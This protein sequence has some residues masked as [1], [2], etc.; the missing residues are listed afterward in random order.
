[1]IRRLLCFVAVLIVVSSQL[2]EVAKAEQFDRNFYST[3][4][5]LFYDPRCDDGTATA[6]KIS[7]NGKDNIEKILKFLMAP[8]QG[9]TLAQ[10]SG[11]I[12]NLMAESGQNIDAS[13]IQGGGHADKNYVPVNGTGF[14]IAQWTF[15]ARQVPLQNYMRPYNDIT[16]LDGQIGFMWSELTGTHG[17]ALRQ[18]KQTS[19]PLDAAIAFH[20]YYEGS[21]D[22]AAQVAAN[23]GGNAEKVY[24]TYV[25]EPALAGSTGTPAT[26]NVADP[27]ST[28]PNAGDITGDES[29]LPGVGGGDLIKTVKAYAWPTYKGLTTSPT[30][31]YDSAVQKA[32]GQGRYVG[33]I[34]YPGIDCGGFVTTLVIDSGFDKDYNYSGLKSKGAGYTGIQETWLKANWKQ[35][36]STDATDRQPGDVAIN[37]THTYIFVGPTAFPNHAPIA[38]ASL[39]ERAPMQGNESVATA[40]FRWYRKPAVAPSTSS[41]LS[42]TAGGNG[43]GGSI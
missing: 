39:D 23:R 12:G 2:V 32:I 3:N 7:L 21:A 20:K 29:C 31:A 43:G 24:N 4:D 5:I 28:N 22:S 11:I 9:L 14:G 36:S 16:S 41:S 27:T 17:E 34:S 40:S 1:M 42:S 35:I 38:S 25:D 10:A 8:A 33:G 18:I 26:D 37:D 19:T 15:S 30:D 13:I 6:E